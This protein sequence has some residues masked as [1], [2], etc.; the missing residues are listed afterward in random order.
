[1]TDALCYLSIAELADAY[2]TGATSP[3]E[4]VSELLQ[5]IADKD[6]SLHSYA[7][8][9]AEGAIRCAEVAAQELRSGRDRG[10]L[11]GVPVAVKDLF[12]THD[13]PTRAG[14]SVLDSQPAPQ[15]ATAVA[16]LRE[17]GAILL[18]KL[19]L[20]EGA[21]G[22]HHP[23]VQTPINPWGTDLWSGI[24]SSGAGVATSAG[25]C[26]ASLAT[27]T[28][29]SIRFPSSSCGLTG[30]KPTWGRVSRA[31]IFPVIES[32]D[33]AGPIAR[34]ATDAAL[35]LEVLAG[36]DE[37]DLTATFRPV[38]KYSAGLD[39]AVRGVIIGIDEDLMAQGVDDEVASAVLQ[40]SRALSAAGAEL[41]RVR[42]PDTDEGLTAASAGLAAQIALAH[43]DTFPRRESAYGP[44]LRALLS[45]AQQATAEDV[46]NME[47]VRTRLRNQVEAVL[48]E[49]AVLLLPVTPFVTP[50]AAEGARMMLD[51]AGIGRATRFTS[52]F[53]LTGHPALTIPCAFDHRGAPIGLQLVGGSFEEGT[54]LRVADA[55][56]RLSDHHRRRPSL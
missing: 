39:G 55:F 4:A 54:L 5:R 16:R 15:D 35:V 19:Q 12:F 20:T 28:G 26:H 3:V 9:A 32:L 29:G 34:S 21:C 49:V 37:R 11:H 23:A 14:M 27:D 48:M 24:S 51:P 56:Q 38:P 10:P 47:R 50:T 8:I 33:H 1:M 6:S 25:L 53:N 43:R 42:M 45:A 44:A 46:I 40:A 18:G 30:L 2:R 31:G 17:A 13:M 7:H 22:V 41:R 36:A 52:I